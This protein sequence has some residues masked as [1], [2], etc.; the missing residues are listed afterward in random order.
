MPRDPL[1]DAGVDA[2]HAAGVAPTFV[3]LLVQIPAAHALWHAQR[4]LFGRFGLGKVAGM[5]FHKTL[6]SGYE[7]GFGLRPS[8]TRH[9]FMAFFADAACARAFLAGDFVAGYRRHASELFCAVLTPVTS[10]GSWNGF[11]LD[12]PVQTQ[13]APALPADT[14]VAALTRGSINPLRAPLFWSK[15]APAQAAVE[16]APGCQLA[17]G[18][19][20][21]PLLRQAT[22]SLWDSVAAMDAYA[23]RGAHLAA[24]K[25]SHQQGFFTES[26]FVRFVPQSVH[27]LWRGQRY[28]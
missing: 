8:F 15:A 19:G 13:A 28:A 12:L 17:V 4:F 16:Q 20:E 24:I 11:T 22:F 23:R 1:P 14:P 18:L 5:R 10:R 21:A 26:M 7:G 6:G 27:G 9:G 2:P 3:V 25:A